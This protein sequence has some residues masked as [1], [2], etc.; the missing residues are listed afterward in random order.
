MKFEPVKLTKIIEQNYSHL[1]PDFFEMQTEYLASLNL[2]YNDLDAS[3]VAM[4]LTSQIYKN[5]F[6]KINSKDQISLNYFYQKK[7]LDYHL[8]LLK[9]KKFHQLLTFREKQ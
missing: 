2:I 1:M 7:I 9:L 6:N 5:K 4:V 3:L 8:Q